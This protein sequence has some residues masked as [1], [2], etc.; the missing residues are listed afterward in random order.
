MSGK[1]SHLR[2]TRRAFT[3][4]ELLVVIAIIAILAAILF[5]VFAQAR[6]KARQAG[7]LSNQKQI[8]T[9]M[10][11]YTQDYDEVLPGNTDGEPSCGSGGGDA[12][13]SLGFMQPVNPAV[14]GLWNIVPRDLQPYVKNLAVFRCPQ[15]APRTGSPTFAD[16]VTTPGGGSSSYLFNGVVGQR[17]LAIMP[18]PADLI[19]IREED[20]ANRYA[21]Q[22]PYRNRTNGLWLGANWSSYDKI[23][24][25]GANLLFCDGHAKWQRKVSIRFSQ[26]GL[27]TT[28]P[29]RTLVIENTP[30]VAEGN[31][32][33]PGA[34]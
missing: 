26:L 31:T 14:R 8:G 24:N 32:G 2:S 6:A 18:A 33:F 11:L 22:R 12:S 5:P 20:F 3:L 34:F 23:H 21:S 4:I 25:E 9:A 7:C 16:T 29:D 28:P 30:A 17:P 19:Y 15:S 13:T 1:R 10:M 27:V